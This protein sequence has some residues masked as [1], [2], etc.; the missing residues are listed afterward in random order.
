MSRVAGGFALAALAALAAA[1]AATAELP[2]GAVQ[3]PAEQQRWQAG[4]PSLPPGTQM[5]VLDGDPRATGPFTM[6]LRVPAGTRLAPHWHPQPER[7]TVLAG[8]A[9]VGFGPRFDEAALR[10]LRAG[11]YYVN[12]PR[13]AHFLAFPEDSILQVSSE[14]PWALHEG[15]PP[16]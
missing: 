9:A 5:M 6:R 1:T 14:G 2:A 3:A 8:A 7:V 15:V 12:P 16:P 11:S 10:V 13:T 4:P